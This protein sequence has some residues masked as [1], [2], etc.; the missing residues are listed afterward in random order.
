MLALYAKQDPTFKPIRAVLT[1][2]WHVRTSQAEFEILCTGPKFWDVRAKV[3]GCGAIDL[4]M[5]LLS[6]DFKRAVKLLRE[7]GL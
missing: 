2:R 4:A 5:H 1:T 3:G 6:I 7:L